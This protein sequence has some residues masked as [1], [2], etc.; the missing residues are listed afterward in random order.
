MSKKN[1]KLKIKATLLYNV[2]SLGSLGT[3]LPACFWGGDD[4]GREAERERNEKRS[5]GKGKWEDRNE[6]GGNGKERNGKI[7]NRKRGAG[8]ITLL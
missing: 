8:E 1:E 4:W 7:K 6:E 3:E 5:T 2:V